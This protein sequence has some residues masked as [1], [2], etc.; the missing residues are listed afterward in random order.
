MSTDRAERPSVLIFIPCREFEGFKTAYFLRMSVSYY[1]LEETAFSVFNL[2][3][4]KYSHYSSM[5]PRGFCEVK[6]SRFRYIG[7]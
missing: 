2:K 7:T 4:L 5:G 6:A 1:A 3:K